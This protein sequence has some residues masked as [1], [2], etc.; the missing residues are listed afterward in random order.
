M[1]A[2]T[3]IAIALTGII[4]ATLYIINL[5]RKNERQNE[6]FNAKRDNQLPHSGFRESITFIL[7]EDKEQDNPYYAEAENYYLFN[8]E[9][10]TTYVITGI[11]F[12]TDVLQ[13]LKDNPPVNQMPWGTIN[14]VSHGNQWIG[15]SAQIAPGSGRTTAERLDAYLANDT[16][17]VLSDNITDGHT[18]IYVRGCGI[19]NNQ[20]LIENI[21]MLFRN[22][23]SAPVVRA[24]RL[25]EYYT[26]LKK[27][28]KVT[29]AQRY[30]AMAWLTSYKMG[31]VPDNNKIMADLSDKY[32]NA[33]INW[34]YALSK[35]CP[36]WAGDLF[37]YTF[38]VPVKWVVNIGPTDALPDFSSQKSRHDWVKRQKEIT[39]QLERL[40]ISSDKFNWWLRKVYVNNT[41]GT[42]SPAMWVKGY[43][44]I[45]CVVQP[46]TDEKQS[47][48]LLPQPF[49]PDKYNTRYFYT[50]KYTENKNYVEDNKYPLFTKAFPDNKFYNNVLSEPIDAFCN[51]TNKSADTGNK[52]G[53]QM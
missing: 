2:N 37:H 29:A 9:E 18:I 34:Q 38:E 41:D 49:I 15:L 27:D 6:G 39:G 19:G 45:V 11:R 1:K 31:D 43:S 36:A 35:T 7:G 5:N 12:L 40:K 53:K 22:V 30:Y 52:P 46:L 47:G 33:F 10:K 13:Y 42:K 3:K 32:P 14:L 44:T 25:F 48:T 20:R 16:L 28:G 26:S 4:I 24:S 17:M 21:G 51:S 23:H 8:K 50:F